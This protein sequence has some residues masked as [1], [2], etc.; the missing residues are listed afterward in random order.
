MAS[1]PARDRQGEGRE[2]SL[3][4]LVSL[5]EGALLGNAQL[6]NQNHAIQT[7]GKAGQG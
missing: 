6:P 1:D 3:D 7:K 2:A 4:G 5:I